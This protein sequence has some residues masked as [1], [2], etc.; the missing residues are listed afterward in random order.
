MGRILAIDYGGKRCGIAVSDP[1]R[2]IA[3]PL[4]AVA[5]ADIKQW[6]AN[7]IAKE[8]VD[9][10]VV[11]VPQKLKGG[12]THSSEMIRQFMQWFRQQFQEIELATIDERFTSSEAQRSMLLNGLPKNKRKDKS[13]VDTISATLILQTY[14]QQIS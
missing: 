14:L 8:T 1:M 13:M 5:S 3:S 2:M 12:D 4:A 7:Y 9:I 6:L 10:V 11:G